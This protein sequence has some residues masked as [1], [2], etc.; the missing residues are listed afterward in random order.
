MP[1]PSVSLDRVS[2]AL[3][4][5]IAEEVLPAFGN[6]RPGDVELK[7]TA[8][9][10]RGRRVARGSRGRGTP[11]RGATGARTGLTGCRRRSSARRRRLL[12]SLGSD[13]PVW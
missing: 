3:R 13:G 1:A 7:R 2:E 6:L 12:A 10:P 9:D 8:N 5:V 4:I 11:G